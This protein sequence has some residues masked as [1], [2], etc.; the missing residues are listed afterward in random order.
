MHETL[1][2]E[3][4]WGNYDTRRSVHYTDLFVHRLAFIALLPLIGC[5]EG[6]LTCNNISNL[7]RFPMKTREGPSRTQG[8]HD[9]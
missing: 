4:T 5:Q 7:K 3:H 1:T 6:H 8:N 2:L 9:R